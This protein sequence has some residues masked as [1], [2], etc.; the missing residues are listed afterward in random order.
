M[1]LTDDDLWNLQKELLKEPKK[2]S[3]IP[4]TGGLRKIRVPLA[5][6]GKR[7]SARACYVDFEIARIIYLVYC[8]PKNK[9]EDLTV[10]EKRLAT[11]IIDEAKKELNE[12]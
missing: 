7:G 2:G 5:D 8:Y 9:K 12:G 11:K 3:V 10:E 4:G 6:R 1:N